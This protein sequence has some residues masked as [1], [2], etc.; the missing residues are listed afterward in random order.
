[1]TLSR[2]R[3]APASSREETH[4]AVLVTQR[5]AE[6]SAAKLARQ[7]LILFEEALSHAGQSQKELAETLG[8]TPGRVSQLLHG[9]GN[10]RIAS[11]ARAMDALGYEVFLSAESQSLPAIVPR[12]RRPHHNV[13]VLEP[14]RDTIYSSDQRKSTVR[15]VEA[16]AD[17]AVPPVS[18]NDLMKRV[19][20]SQVVM[21]G[22]PSELSRRASVLGA[23]QHDVSPVLR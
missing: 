11:L 8:V 10:V 23:A 1:M 16:P 14:Y 21:S 15:I 9:D 17:E 20:F 3:P 6:R 2:R 13:V 18:P 7:V 22:Q 4:D 19:R 12:V 5:R